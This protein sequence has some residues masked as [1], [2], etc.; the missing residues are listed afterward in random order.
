MAKSDKML[1][2]KWDLLVKQLDTCKLIVQQ[3]RQ[4]SS[5]E[6]LE[7][8]HRA[9]ALTLQLQDLTNDTIKYL[10]KTAEPSEDL[11]KIKRG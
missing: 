3:D 7:W 4:M 9:D 6:V 5:D 11:S 1:Y 8:L 2:G 10:A